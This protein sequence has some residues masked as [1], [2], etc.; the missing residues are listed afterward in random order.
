[1]PDWMLLA[2]FEPGKLSMVILI[3]I[4]L[5]GDNAI[6]IGMA[7]CAVPLEYRQRAIF[8]GIGAAVFF[9][10]LFSMFAFYLLQIKGLELIGG[11]L[12]LWVCWRLW[13]DLRD[14]HPHVVNVSKDFCEVHDKSVIGAM[15]MRKAMFNII[16]ADV[17]M[18][19]DNVIAVASIARGNLE[20]LVLGLMLSVALMAVGATWLAKL[21]DR[22]YW[23]GYIGLA[24]IVIVA[25][26][27]IW[28]GLQDLNLT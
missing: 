17:S 14:S 27:L 21:L 9:R 2:N 13:N 1:M 19:L 26:D 10:V 8:Y 16:V 11:L 28:S 20:V 18:S 3:D 4:I 23:L 5:S 22:F 6:I 7:A 25:G 15:T 12:L 24:I